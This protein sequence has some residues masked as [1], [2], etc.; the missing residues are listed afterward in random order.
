M[1]SIKL[2]NSFFKKMVPVG[3]LGLHK[4]TIRDFGVTLLLISSRSMESEL[5]G[6]F[7]QVAPAE[8]T[9]ISYIRNEGCGKITSSPGFS[10]VFVNILM[11]S[12][13]PFPKTIFSGGTFSFSEILFIR[14]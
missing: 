10:S 1:L 5:R 7:T 3:L 11:I 2:S 14:L 6:T 12:S 8:R 13:E 4:K 9:I